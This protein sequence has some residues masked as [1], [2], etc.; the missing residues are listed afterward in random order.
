[1]DA[2]RAAAE[3]MK[4]AESMALDKKYQKSTDFK[5][6]RNLKH[7]YYSRRFFEKF[8]RS[9]NLGYSFPRVVIPGYMNSKVRFC[10]LLRRH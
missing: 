5:H 9:H 7:I 8:A 3:L 6:R 1:M 2:I 10:V 4:K